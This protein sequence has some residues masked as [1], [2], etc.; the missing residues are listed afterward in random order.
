MRIGD[1]LFF[2]GEM[3]PPKC[4]ALDGGDFCRQNGKEKRCTFQNETEHF[5]NGTFH[6][7]AFTLLSTCPLRRLSISLNIIIYFF[8]LF[9]VLPNLLPD[10]FSTKQSSSHWIRAAPKETRNDVYNDEMNHDLGVRC[11]GRRVFI[12]PMVFFICLCRSSRQRLLFCD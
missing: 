7:R 9:F 4:P 11:E 8:P 5:P 3:P 1:S 12:F 10:V 6:S 2:K